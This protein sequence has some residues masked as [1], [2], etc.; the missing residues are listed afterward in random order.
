MTENRMHH[1]AAHESPCTTKF[2]DCTGD[3]ITLTEVERLSGFVQRLT[4]WARSILEEPRPISLKSCVSSVLE[5][6]HVQGS[7]GHSVHVSAC[8]SPEPWREC[9][10]LRPG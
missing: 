2:H 9:A 7:A 1:V 4:L 3:E 8:V 10:T 5:R 6:H